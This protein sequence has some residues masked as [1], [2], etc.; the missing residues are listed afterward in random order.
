MKLIQ[1][2][3]LP[4]SIF[5]KEKIISI[6][7]IQPSSS[8]AT[9]GPKDPRG[10]QDQ[11]CD[12]AVKKSKPRKADKKPGTWGKLQDP[13]IAKTHHIHESR[14][15]QQ[16]LV[17][18]MFGES[19]INYRNTAAS[20]PKFMRAFDAT[21]VDIICDFNSPTSI[22]VSEIQ[23]PFPTCTLSLSKMHLDNMTHG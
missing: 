16:D 18:K 15:V 13:P 5:P 23:W 22:R 21:Q 17:D 4:I 12:A 10:G 9:P 3:L 8:T 19:S 6:I 14:W 7:S 20:K 1:W 11:T 2:L